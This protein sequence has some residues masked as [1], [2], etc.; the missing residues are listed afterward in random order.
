LI[1]QIKIPYKAKYSY[2][3]R[4]VN[5]KD[6]L[7]EPGSLGFTYETIAAIIVNEFGAIGDLQNSRDLFIKKAKGEHVEDHSQLVKEIE[8]KKEEAIRL[9]EQLELKEKQ[10]KR[11]RRI[12]NRIFA[13]L[14]AAL[15]VAG[16]VIS[17]DGLKKHTIEKDYNTF[18]LLLAQLSGQPDSVRDVELCKLAN[19]DNIYRDPRIETKKD[20]LR[21]FCALQQRID[22]SKTKIVQVADT[23]SQKSRSNRAFGQLDTLENRIQLTSNEIQYASNSNTKLRLQGDSIQLELQKQKVISS[24]PILSK[25]AE[26][27]A[28]LDS[29]IRQK[30]DISNQIIPVLKTDSFAVDYQKD[31]WFKQGY[32]LQFNNIRVSL[33]KLDPAAQSV[34]LEVCATDNDA[35]IMGLKT[36]DVKVSE[37]LLFDYK[38]V[39]YS[40][41]INKIGR[42]GYNPF[43]QAA[44]IT[45]VRFK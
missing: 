1:N 40:I 9:N 42:A 27:T 16:V 35:C 37:E 44:Y 3:E 2:G 29:A 25:L 23:I 31:G 43:T 19:Y 21:T 26:P 36:A 22:L 11:Q 18:V 15:F 30:D 12:R 17:L 8:Q 38:S 41:K 28:K 4:L 45:F 33:T 5:L 24:N 32:F 13:L 6:E 10:A 20:S 14:A 39:K 34:S 7:E